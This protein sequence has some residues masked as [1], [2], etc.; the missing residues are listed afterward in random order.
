MNAKLIRRLLA[1][2]ALALCAPAS[3]SQASLTR[4]DGRITDAGKSLS[5]VQVVLSNQDTFQAYHATTDKYGTFSIPDVARGAYI[6]SI[7]NAA[8]DKLF[9]K[10]LQLPSASDAPIRLDLDISG[11]P[12]ADAPAAPSTAPR[13]SPLPGSAASP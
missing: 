1:A 8:G 12:A 7:L 13:E 5:G 11:A 6:V 4:A 10:P 3:W 9:R 2:V